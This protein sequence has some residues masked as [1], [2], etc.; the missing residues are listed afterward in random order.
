MKILFNKNL[1]SAYYVR[2]AVLG[3]QTSPMNK[4]DET[5]L[6]MCCS[7]ERQKINNRYYYGLNYVPLQ[8]HM[9]KP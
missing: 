8:M 7:N 2:S 5:T 6:G 1:S 4:T 3:S 9:L